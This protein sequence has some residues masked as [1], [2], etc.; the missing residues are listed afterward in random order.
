M[1]PL[2]RL[3][4][5]PW[6]PPLTDGLVPVGDHIR[7]GVYW[8]SGDSFVLTEEGQRLAQERYGRRPDIRIHQYT[9]CQ[10]E[11]EIKHALSTIAALNKEADEKIKTPAL[12]SGFKKTP[13]DEKPQPKPEGKSLEQIH[14]ELC[15]AIISIKNFKRIIANQRP[16]RITRLK[17]NA[18]AFTNR[19]FLRPMEKIDKMVPRISADLL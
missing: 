18:Y 6:P 16:D 15:K 5:A 19:Y 13:A 12:K 3:A 17:V 4:P 1:N 10:A 8:N 9:A 7:K 14:L 11:I 2:S